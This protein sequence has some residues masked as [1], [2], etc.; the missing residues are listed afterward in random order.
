MVHLPYTH[1]GE[2]LARGDLSGEGVAWDRGPTLVNIAVIPPSVLNRVG[3]LW[4]TSRNLISL[5][6][7]V[8][9]DSDTEVVY[10]GQFI[11]NVV[12]FCKENV[13]KCHLGW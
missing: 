11:G 5:W 3:T 2:G 12:A 1:A 13:L 8:I 10:G 6:M 9:G 4:S 7:V